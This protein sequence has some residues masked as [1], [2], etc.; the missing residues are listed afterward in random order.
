MTTIELH[1]RVATGFQPVAD[2]FLANFETRGDTAASCAIYADGALVVDLWAGHT[3]QGQWSPDLRTVMFSVSKGI[4]TICLLMAVERGLIELDAPVVT[5]W[6]EFGVQQKHETTVRQVLAHQAGLPAPDRDLT[7]LDVRAWVPVVGALA[8]QAPAW[9]PGT[10][11][12]YHALSF[13]WLVGE[14]LRRTTGSRPSEW[15]AEQICGPLG[16]R[17]GFGVDPSEADYRPMEDPLPTTDLV[18]ARWQAEI[19]DVPMVVRAMSLGA[20]FDFNDVPAITTQAHF[21]DAEIPGANLVANARGLARLYAATVSEV[22]GVRLLGP[23]TVRDARAVQTLGTPYVGADEGNRWG[24]GFMVASP[25]RPMAGPGSFGHDGL[26]GLL[27]FAHLE[28]KISFAYQTI[29]P[30]GIPDDRAEALC[31]AL[32]ACI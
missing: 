6:P 23:E 16:I 26:G 4:T 21:L 5:Y 12:G 29:R 28:S 7:P 8:G 22:D 11:H 9:P 19:L 27:A 17:M 3:E 31:R 1:G 15:L 10:A 25:R 13:G 14:L 32:R 24:T 30:G 18:T 2:A 20:A